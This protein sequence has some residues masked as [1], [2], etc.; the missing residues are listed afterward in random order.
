MSVKSTTPKKNYKALYLN[1]SER[2][3]VLHG[4]ADSLIVSGDFK[5]A[6]IGREL[7]QVAFGQHPW[8]R[9]I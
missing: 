1:L 3:S 4:M 9:K 2:I 8:S 6:N 5:I 7:K